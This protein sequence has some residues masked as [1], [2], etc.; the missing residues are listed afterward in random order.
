MKRFFS[1][2]AL[3]AV[4]LAGCCNLPMPLPL[5]GTS[6]TPVRIG[7]NAVAP[8]KALLVIDADGRVHGNG[9]VNGFFGSATVDAETGAIRFSENMGATLMA[10]P[11]EAMAA[12]RSLF[13]ALGRVRGYRISCDELTF[14]DGAGNPVVVFRGTSAADGVE[15]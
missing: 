15:K 10:G 8:G 6:W 3:V 11:E 4:I 14:L 13:E 12:E 5:A 7:E 2:A 1:L 9:G